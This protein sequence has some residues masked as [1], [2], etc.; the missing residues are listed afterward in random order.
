M[1]DVQSEPFHHDHQ[2]SLTEQRSDRWRLEQE[3]QGR[4]EQ[5][6]TW[7]CPREQTGRQES[8]QFLCEVHD[9]PDA[10]GQ[11]PEKCEMEGHELCHLNRARE[12]IERDPTR[13]PLPTSA[14]VAIEKAKRT[15]SK[16]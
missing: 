10:V 16:E 7:W 3:M 6:V 8:C 4:Q 15:L 5:S 12:V 9:V 14:L 1:K 2:M 13:Q 11:G